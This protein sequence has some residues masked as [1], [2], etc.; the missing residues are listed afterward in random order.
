M[1][2]LAINKDLQFNTLDVLDAKVIE[3]MDQ[4]ELLTLLTESIH[5]AQVEYRLTTPEGIASAVIIDMVKAGLIVIQPE[6]E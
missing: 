3:P 4:T 6:T 5:F 1:K 2:F